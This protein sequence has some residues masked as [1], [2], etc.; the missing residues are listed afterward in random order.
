MSKSV[1]DAGWGQFLLI[2]FVKAANAGLQTIAVNPNGTTQDCSICGLRRERDS[3]ERSPNVSAER[4]KVPKELSERWHSC[5]HCGCE[6]D[7]DH[8]AAINI[9]KRAV[10]HPVQA[11]RGDRNAEPVTREA[12]TVV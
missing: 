3:T 7:R 4:V 10:G 11:L 1:N 8:N 2:L 12:R 6:L 9:Q 5:P